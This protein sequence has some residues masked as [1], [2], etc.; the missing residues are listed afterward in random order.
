LWRV[1]AATDDGLLDN[2]L[3]RRPAAQ[4]QP[5]PAATANDDR[6]IAA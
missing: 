1:P 6:A 5:L 3:V 4:L 2:P